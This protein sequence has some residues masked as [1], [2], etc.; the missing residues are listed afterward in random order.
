MSVRN[1]KAHKLPWVA[2]QLDISLRQ[3]YNLIQSGDLERIKIG[4]S[5]RITDV[6]YQEYFR[7]RQDEAA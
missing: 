2:S 1:T 3:V 4:R 5:A 7:R 6:S